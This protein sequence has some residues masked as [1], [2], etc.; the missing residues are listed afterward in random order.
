MGSLTDKRKAEAK[1]KE[2]VGDNGWES[3]YDSDSYKLRGKD[4][5][6][7]SDNEGDSV[8]TRKKLK[9][10]N[11]VYPSFNIRTPMKNV[12][13]ETG[14][15]F[16]DVK[17]LRNAIIDYSVEQRRDIWFKKNDLQRLQAKCMENCT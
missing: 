7:S 15:M 9:K 14:L 17:T 8:G 16:T 1:K 12:E 3:E 6:D 10:S 13:F 11:K 2:V 4:S 5:S